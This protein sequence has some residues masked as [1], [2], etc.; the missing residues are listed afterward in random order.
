MDHLAKLGAVACNISEAPTR[1]LSNVTV[2][3]SVEEVGKEVDTVGLSGDL[4][5]I[6]I[7][8]TDVGQDPG[9]LETAGVGRVLEVRHEDRK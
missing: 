3:V 4:S 2:F 1:L 8:G 5:G 9:S 6:G 7:G